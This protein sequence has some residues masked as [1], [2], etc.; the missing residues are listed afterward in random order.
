VAD[1]ETRAVLFHGLSDLRR[2]AL[3]GAL[4]GGSYRVNDLVEL[5]ALPQPSVSRHL[6]CLHDCGLVEREQ[7][8]R[9]V[10]YS[11]ADGIGDLLLHADRIVE[12]SGERIRS[13]TRYGK[14]AAHRAAA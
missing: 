3:L 9:E 5:T 10:F 4:A 7:R 11:L 14:V 12:T 1:D 6:A 2:L 13:C 8:G